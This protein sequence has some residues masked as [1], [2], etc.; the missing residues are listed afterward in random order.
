M[1]PLT[2][3]RS[4]HA[5]AKC[6]ATCGGAA[7]WARTS[8]SCSS[9]RGARVAARASP[10]DDALPVPP[11]PLATS[12]EP[13]ELRRDADWIAGMVAL[14]LDEEWC[15]QEVH[16]DLGRAAGDAYARIRAGGEDEMGGLLLG[17]CSDLSAFN[18][19]ECF[20]GPFDVA[21][22][23]V[24]MLMQRGGTDVCCTSGDDDTR[25]DRY[26]ARGRG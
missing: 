14:W 12:D 21:N 11:A 3:G 18:Y 8:S 22:K 24:E 15:P 6:R 16:A 23:V 25:A 7:A 9:S 5:P 10:A 1:R 17:L 4:A 26:D 19:R 13:E 20:V 2:L